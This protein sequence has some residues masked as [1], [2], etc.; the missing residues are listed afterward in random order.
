MFGGVPVH[1]EQLVFDLHGV[2]VRADTAGVG[3]LLQ[4]WLKCGGGLGKV[5]AGDAG[6]ELGRKAGCKIHPP[7]AGGLGV[8]DICRDGFVAKRD[9]V[10]ELAGNLIIVR[11]NQR[12]DHA[13]GFSTGGAIGE[14]AGITC[15]ISRE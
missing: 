2:P 12:F 7:V 9:G 6:L 3:I 13:R 1:L 8:G 11:R 4:G 14:R 10:E 15:L 5:A